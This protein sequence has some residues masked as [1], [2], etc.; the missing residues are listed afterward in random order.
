MA[1]RLVAWGLAAVLALASGSAALAQQAAE[2]PK[3]SALSWQKK[4][5]ETRSTVM[6]VAGELEQIGDKGNP[7]AKGL[8]DDAKRWIGEG[9]KSTA[10]ADEKMKSEE[11]Q[12]A[13]SDY[14]MAWQHYVR[15][16]TAGLNA[17]R[18]LT[19]E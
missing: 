7:I 10:K 2:D 17:K 5:S 12:T 16:A 13:S 4:A 8:I 1:L 14:N 3:Q 9:D 11:Y 6:G 19:G 15:A 18:V